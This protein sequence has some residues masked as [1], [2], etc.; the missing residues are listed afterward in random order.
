MC[1]SIFIQYIFSYNMIP[2]GYVQL[3]LNDSLHRSRYLS[4]ENEDPEDSPRANYPLGR[5]LVVAEIKGL[6][7]LSCVVVRSFELTLLSLR[8]IQ[9]NHLAGAGNCVVH[10]V[11][12]KVVR[13]PAS[14]GRS[15]TLQSC[16]KFKS[17]KIELSI[18]LQLRHTS[19]LFYDSYFIIDTAS[20]KC[21]IDQ[22]RQ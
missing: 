6:R 16:V 5:S 13:C 11:E 1:Y 12:A 19:N 18:N 21:F 7:L 9:S 3:I 2:W 4:C 14:S 20:V 22:R 10:R 8:H 17:W 15:W